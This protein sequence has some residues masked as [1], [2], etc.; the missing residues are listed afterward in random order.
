M[1][2]AIT[3][4]IDNTDMASLKERTVEALKAEGFG[5]LTE[6]DLQATLKKKLNKDHLPHVILG[7]C[8]PGFA[9]QVITLE[10]LISTMLPC[11]VIIRQLPDGKHQVA[12]ID[13]AAAMSAVDNPTV[14][15][16][17]VLVRD[18]L[19]WAVEQV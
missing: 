15:P 8:N 6:I 1:K 17:A 13:P 12:A 10:P 18:A 11:N 9:D 4:T 5:V 2:Y 7:A 19:K 3:R 16:I 14:E